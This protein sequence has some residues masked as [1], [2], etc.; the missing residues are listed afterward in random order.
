MATIHLNLEGFKRRVADP[1]TMHQN[2]NFL[3]TKPAVIDFYA[4][5]DTAPLGRFNYLF[6]E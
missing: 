5:G 2:W 1:T 6:K 3:G 4:N